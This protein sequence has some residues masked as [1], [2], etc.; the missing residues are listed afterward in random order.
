MSYKQ[1]K[2]NHVTLLL[3]CKVGVL[4]YNLLI[5]VINFCEGNRIQSI[6]MNMGLLGYCIA[7]AKHNLINLRGLLYEL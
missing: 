6:I 2:I 1:T 7:E 4:T 5:T 3:I